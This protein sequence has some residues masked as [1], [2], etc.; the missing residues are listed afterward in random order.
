MPHV[1]PSKANS[2][3]GVTN[4][5]RAGLN[6]L[7]YGKLAPN[8]SDD[9]CPTHLAYM[10]CVR[11]C[12]NG[13]VIGTPPTTMPCLPTVTRAEPMPVPG[14]PPEAAPGVTTLRSPDAPPGPMGPLDD[15]SGVYFLGRRSERDLRRCAIFFAGAHRSCWAVEQ[16]ELIKVASVFT[17]LAVIVR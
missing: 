15:A 8:Q 13:A 1:A 5:P 16:R 4:L 7:P 17:E 6:T 9:R 2:F 11:T 12:T 10:K 14:G 3:R